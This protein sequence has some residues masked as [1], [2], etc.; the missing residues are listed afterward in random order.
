[1]SQSVAVSANARFD[2][3]ARHILSLP[4]GVGLAE[5]LRRLPDAWELNFQ[6][7]TDASR[8]EHHVHC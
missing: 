6:V 1:M 5:A 4:A 2:A 7:S 8:H 3:S